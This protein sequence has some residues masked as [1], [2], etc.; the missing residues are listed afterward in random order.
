MVLKRSGNLLCLTAMLCLSLIFLTCG[1][2][3]AQSTYNSAPDEGAFLAIFCFA[4]L[5]VFIIIIV[6]AI[7][8]YKDANSRG[9]N[10]TLWLI[11][12]LVSSIIGLIIYLILRSDH[13]MSQQPQPPEPIRIKYAKTV[14]R[15]PSQRSAYGSSQKAQSRIRQKSD[16]L[17]YENKNEVCPDCKYVFTSHAVLKDGTKTFELVCPKCNS[18]IVKK[19][20]KTGRTASASRVKAVKRRK[21]TSKKS[22]TEAKGQ[23]KSK[24]SRKG[25]K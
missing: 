9:M 24:S 18:T 10:G 16:M 13:P 25:K 12:I 11:V 8:V 19:I 21:T 3:N 2:A 17:E 6:I 23:K 7:W 1:S 20:T 4:Y 15:A 14:T 5:I 22:K